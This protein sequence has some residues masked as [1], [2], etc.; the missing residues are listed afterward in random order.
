[1]IGCIYFQVAASELKADR[2]IDI[3][4][5]TMT[6]AV[7]R[8]ARYKPSP[9]ESSYADCDES[10]DD[11]SIEKSFESAIDESL[12]GRISEDVNWKMILMM[13]LTYSL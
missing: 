6:P 10:R 4:M 12:V 13:C 8:I 5:R 9:A 3:V 7:S 11:L 1:M 2:K